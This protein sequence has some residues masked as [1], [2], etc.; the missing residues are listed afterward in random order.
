MVSGK[1]MLSHSGEMY[2]TAVARIIIKYTASNYTTINTTA[3][4]S[5]A[6]A[7]TLHFFVCRGWCPFA[8]TANT[9]S[10]RVRYYTLRGG[11]NLLL[12]EYFS[13]SG[14][15]IYDDTTALLLLYGGPTKETSVW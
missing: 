11:G 12:V 15:L 14:T 9:A 6:S 10:L 4:T 1:Y 13:V 8:R 5:S 7:C 2:V 3:S